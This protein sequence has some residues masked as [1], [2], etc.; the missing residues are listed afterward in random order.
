[1]TAETASFSI[2]ADLYQL[3]R[4][5]IQST[6]ARIRI[7]VQFT[8]NEAKK[9][10]AQFIK[11]TPTIIKSTVRIDGLQLNAI[12]KRQFPTPQPTRTIVPDY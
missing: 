1:M 10:A 3:I 2:S 5:Q 6:N 4:P 7:K 8:M 12:A 9:D 11:K